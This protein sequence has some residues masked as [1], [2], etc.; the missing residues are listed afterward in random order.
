[1]AGRGVGVSKSARNASPSRSRSNVRESAT[2]P[3]TT[4]ATHKM[5]DTTA[6]VG[7]APATTNAKLKM[8]TMTTARNAVVTTISRLRHSI[9]RSLRAICHTCMKNEGSAVPGAGRVSATGR[10]LVKLPDV[11]RREQGLGPAGITALVAR[12]PAAAQDDQMVG[13]GGRQIE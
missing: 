9:A 11:A 4:T 10:L 1:M 5:P 7:G 6:G 8:S 3:D 12:H 2:V 13:G